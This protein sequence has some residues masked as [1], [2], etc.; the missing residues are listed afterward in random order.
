MAEET[1]P[2]QL[3][4]A[5]PESKLVALSI[6]LQLRFRTTFYKWGSYVGSAPFTVMIVSVILTA[7]FASGIPLAAKEDDDPQTS[8]V[9]RG[10]QGVEDRDRAE[11]IFG[12]S[13]RPIFIW[14]EATGDNLVTKQV[15][16]LLYEFDLEIRTKVATTV[17]DKVYNW[18]ELCNKSEGSTSCSLNGH[19]LAFWANEDAYPNPSF[20][21][22]IQE[23]DS[24]AVLEQINSGKSIS[25]SSRTISIEN[26]FGHTNPSTLTVN[27]SGS[28][29]VYNLVSAK[30]MRWNYFLSNIKDLA[31]DE[32]YDKWESEFMDVVKR[33]NAS[34]SVVILH[35]QTFHAFLEAFRESIGGDLILLQIGI[36][37]IIGYSMFVISK[38]QTI[39]AKV[40]LALM[41]VASVGMAY[42]SSYGLASYFGQESSGVHNLLLFLLLGIGV[43]DMYVIVHA[44]EQ[45]DV[46]WAEKRNMSSLRSCLN[47]HSWL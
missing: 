20:Q 2:A 8:W 4:N 9:P 44:F 41:G 22:V 26:M 6:A 24:A 21:A 46:S 17:D 1:N 29:P 30:A 19:P 14:A 7:A 37:L 16:D 43:D 12:S 35:V 15:Y 33:F 31:N 38:F 25:N 40:F 45:T 42:A 13:A 36:F 10:S 47:L 34:Q 32:V 28:G 3:A 27:E 11:D 5:Q 18:P 39:R 23:A